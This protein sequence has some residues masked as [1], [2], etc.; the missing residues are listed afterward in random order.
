[1]D[2]R[3]F[4]EKVTEIIFTKKGYDVKILDLRELTT[5]ADYF[6]ICSADSDVQVKAIADEVDNE[7]RKIGIKPN[8]SEGYNALQWILIDYFD[9]IVHVFHKDAREYY[10]LEK[11]WGDAPVFEVVDKLLSGVKKWKIIW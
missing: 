11:L 10:N 3:T 9:V 5:F 2:T 4:S 1:M 8:H 6:V 7:L